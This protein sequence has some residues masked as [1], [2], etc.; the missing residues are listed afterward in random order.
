[1]SE[2][3]KLLARTEHVFEEFANKQDRMAKQVVMGG[4]GAE[5]EGVC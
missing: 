4:G 1:M 2:L 3:E 5:S